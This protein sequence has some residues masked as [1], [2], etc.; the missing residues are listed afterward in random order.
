[1][2]PRDLK[3]A[4]RSPVSIAESTLTPVHAFADRAWDQFLELNPLVG[5]DAG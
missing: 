2:S 5:H 4:R 1:M 3:P